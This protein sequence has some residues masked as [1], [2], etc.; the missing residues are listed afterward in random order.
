[1]G[2]WDKFK[3]KL[4]RYVDPDIKRADKVQARREQIEK[5]LAETGREVN[6]M[7]LCKEFV[8]QR[9]QKDMIEEELKDVDL[10]IEALTQMIVDGFEDHDMS[11]L[12]MSNGY[13]VAL[14]S[15]PRPSVDDRAAYRKW[16]IENGYED[17]LTLPWQ[18]TKAMVKNLLENGEAQPDGVSVYLAP[19]LLVT[20]SK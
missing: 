16:L 6:P 13:R 18:T 1:M 17:S 7:E 9:A 8:S 12:V 3:G 10:T 4:E 19:K 14:H 20:K 2:K 11:A 15:E 5:K